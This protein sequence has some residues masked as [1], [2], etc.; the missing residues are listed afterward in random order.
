MLSPWYPQGQGFIAATNINLDGNTWVCL[1]LETDIFPSSIG[2]LNASK[3]FL[4][5]SATSSKNNTP[6]CAKD[7]S[8]GM[9][10]IPP[11]T[12]EFVDALWCGDLNG[13]SVI[14]VPLFFKSPATL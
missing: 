12:N 2:C 13:L 8:P 6:L 4:L 3:V 9:A 10:N 1:T 5:N 14:N 7:I 11:P